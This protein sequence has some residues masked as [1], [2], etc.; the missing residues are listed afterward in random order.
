MPLYLTGKKSNV[1]VGLYEYRKIVKKRL[2]GIT[3]D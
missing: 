1:L 2:V 3:I